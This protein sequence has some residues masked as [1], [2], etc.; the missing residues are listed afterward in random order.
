MLVSKLAGTEQDTFDPTEI[1]G[2][3]QK[4]TSKVNDDVRTAKGDFSSSNF[5]F[6]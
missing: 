5:D 2:Q 1:S 4:A 6:P 3:N